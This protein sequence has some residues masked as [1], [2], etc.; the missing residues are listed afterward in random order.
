MVASV[1]VSS[2]THHSEA[3]TGTYP[4]PSHEES[5]L[6]VSS[7]PA[8]LNGTSELHQTNY[9]QNMHLNFSLYIICTGF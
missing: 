8:E 2:F 1:G 5:N 3:M 7:F 4:H 9:N 6:Q